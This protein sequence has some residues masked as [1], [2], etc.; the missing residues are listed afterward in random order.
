MV[1][2]KRHLGDINVYPS[3][4]PRSRQHSETVHIDPGRPGSS[5]VTEV[6]RKDSMA[7]RPKG[8][9][10]RTSYQDTT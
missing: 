8:T 9:G 3:G 7:P 6:H 2:G 1:A 5:K 4:D 10:C